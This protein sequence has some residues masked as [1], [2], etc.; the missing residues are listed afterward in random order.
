M[1]GYEIKD[2][3]TGDNTL[4]ERG[5]GGLTRHPTYVTTSGDK[6]NT[7][8]VDIHISSWSSPVA[9]IVGSKNVS[10]AVNWCIVDGS[11]DGAY[12]EVTGEA[13][14]TESADFKGLCLTT[15]GMTAADVP[16]MALTLRGANDMAAS[17][18]GGV[19]VADTDVDVPTV[20]ASRFVL[21]AVNAPVY[22][23]PSI[24]DISMCAI[25]DRGFTNT[26]LVSMSQDPYQ[27]LIPA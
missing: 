15:P 18:N 1:F 12:S 23:N 16:I 25:F 24:A 22:S 17:T 20:T 19:V 9:I 8:E 27:F 3:V 11:W 6:T 14:I 4:I 5:T 10:G 7:T 21:G 13:R 26:E 2:L